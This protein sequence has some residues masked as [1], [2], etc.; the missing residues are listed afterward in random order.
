MMPVRARAPR[1]IV[2]VAPSVPTPTLTRTGP[3]SQIL[4]SV[5]ASR[6]VLLNGT[7]VSVSL[8]S[9]NLI[10]S[11]DSSSR[12][13]TQAPPGRSRKTRRIFSFTRTITRRT[14]ATQGHTPQDSLQA[15]SYQVGRCQITYVARAAPARAA[16]VVRL[17]HH[18][19]RAS[20]VCPAMYAP[21]ICITTAGL[22]IPP[23]PNL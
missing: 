8:L 21:T 18:V 9:I 13:E 5:V 22:L 19:R 17:L 15:A 4:Q 23:S 10:F 11:T 20:H 7:I 3:R 14:G 6:I 12:Q 16:G 1:V 2:T